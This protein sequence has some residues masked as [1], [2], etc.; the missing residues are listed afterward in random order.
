LDTREYNTIKKHTYYTYA[1]LNRIKGLES[2]AAWAAHHHERADGNGY[3]FHIKGK[4]FSKL[5][6]VMAVADVMTALTEDRPYRDGMNREE[7]IQTL[8]SMAETG[9]ID[10]QTVSLVYNNF[11]HVNN[12][13]S[14]AQRKARKEYERFMNMDNYCPTERKAPSRVQKGSSYPR[15]ACTA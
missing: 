7:A 14:L 9:A 12:V 3:P 10:K 4:D 8:F 6:R 2:I 1:V 11:S 5:A 15:L 13:R